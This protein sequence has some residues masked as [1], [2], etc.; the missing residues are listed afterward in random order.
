MRPPDGVRIEKGEKGTR[1]FPEAREKGTRTFP[2]AGEPIPTQEEGAGSGSDLNFPFSGCEL[3]RQV[4]RQDRT[5]KTHI[6][7][8]QA[9]EKTRVP[10]SAFC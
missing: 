9:L 1:T 3:A 5:E 2:E 4:W 8:E 7:L 6:F 10:F